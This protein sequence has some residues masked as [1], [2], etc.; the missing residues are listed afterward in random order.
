LGCAIERFILRQPTAGC[1]PVCGG[2]QCTPKKAPSHRSRDRT[3]Y[4]AF[5]G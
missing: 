1:S 2:A 4:P 5:A 3:G